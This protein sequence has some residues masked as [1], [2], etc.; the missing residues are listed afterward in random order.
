MSVAALVVLL[1]HLFTKPFEK[2]YINVIEAVILLDLLMVTV[3]FLDPSNTPVP[4]A[5][6][7]VLLLLPYAYAT[8]YIFYRI[9]GKRLWYVVFPRVCVWRG[10][11]Y[12]MTRHVSIMLTFL[13]ISNSLYVCLFKDILPQYH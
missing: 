8:A 1:V 5:F 2:M 11:G 4:F 12:G 10:G 3:A 6:S 7:T 9:L 13:G